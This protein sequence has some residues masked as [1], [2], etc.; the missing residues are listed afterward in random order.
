MCVLEGSL[1]STMS[2]TNYPENWDEIREEVCR[3]YNFRCSNCER[4]KT[5]LEVHHVVPVRLGG[6]HKKSNLTPLCPDCHSAVH[7]DEMA[8]TI[9]WYTNGDL[10]SNEFSAHKRLWKQL[11]SKYGAP[12]YSS[13]RECVYI[14]LADA[15]RIIE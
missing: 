4:T 2:S 7:N 10:S 3:E 6:S 14:P 15:E 9:R 8:P 1:V 11:R 12:R 5:S 13:D